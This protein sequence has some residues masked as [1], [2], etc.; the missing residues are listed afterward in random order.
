MALHIFITRAGI[1]PT[2]VKSWINTFLQGSLVIRVLQGIPT[3]VGGGTVSNLWNSESTCCVK[4]KYGE[5]MKMLSPLMFVR[6]S[7]LKWRGNPHA[8]F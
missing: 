1:V 3:A 4:Y 7:L 6:K 8:M 5:K 2:G